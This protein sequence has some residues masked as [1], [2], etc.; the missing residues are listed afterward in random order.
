MHQILFLHNKLFLIYL[1]TSTPWY[2]VKIFNWKFKQ[3]F[4]LKKRVHF[5]EMGG[6]KYNRI[7][8]NKFIIKYK[9]SLAFISST[10]RLSK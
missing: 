9:N 5:V 2:S 6:S 3:K 7:L 4:K 10:N 8:G 1:Y